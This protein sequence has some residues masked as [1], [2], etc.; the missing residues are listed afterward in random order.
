M[1]WEAIFRSSLKVA[2]RK[3]RRITRRGHGVVTAQRRRTAGGR[4]NGREEGGRE[5]GKAMW[6][7]ERLRIKLITSDNLLIYIHDILS[8]KH[9]M[10]EPWQVLL[11]EANCAR[12][13]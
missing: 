13:I 6:D 1:G 4:D 11:Q 2:S 7:M 9:I 10:S 8:H 3:Q 12:V 5:G